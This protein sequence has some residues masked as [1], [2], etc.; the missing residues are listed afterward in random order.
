MYAFIQGVD[1]QVITGYCIGK[2]MHVGTYHTAVR[3]KL[4]R[5]LI[6]CYHMVPGIHSIGPLC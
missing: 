1:L 5:I 6:P 4:V 2:L 3:P